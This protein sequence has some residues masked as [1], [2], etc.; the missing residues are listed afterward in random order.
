MKV[1]LGC[2]PELFIYDKVLKHYISA[3]DLKIPGTKDKPHPVEGGAILIDGTS[4]EFNI[5]ATDDPKV[6]ASRVK[7]VIKHIEDT[8]LNKDRH[9][10]RAVPCVEY[11]L[12]YWKD[13]PDQ[14]KEFG[15]SPSYN[16]RTNAVVTPPD[17]PKNA[18]TLCTIGGHIHIGWTD[19]VDTS[20]EEFRKD[21]VIVAKTAENF[22]NYNL[23]VISKNLR[24]ELYG[25]NGDMRF[26]PYG[27]EIR[28]PDSFWVMLEENTIKCFAEALIAQITS[29]AKTGNPYGVVW[30]DIA[31]KQSEAL[32]EQ[33]CRF[34]V[35]KHNGAFTWV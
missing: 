18:P 8:Y 11:P 19:G 7:G 20:D 13:L 31:Y 4:V 3:T 1:M 6:F 5:I 15:C 14:V 2:D 10:L 27:V 9:E 12:E 21:A 34:P 26:K 22:V 17:R 30:N 28:S 29:L 33:L 32:V 23:L 16:F 24:K 25:K 35:K